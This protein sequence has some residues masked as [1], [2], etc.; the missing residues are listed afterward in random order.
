MQNLIEHDIL[1]SIATNFSLGNISINDAYKLQR[2]TKQLYDYI[3]AHYAEMK[4]L[5][6]MTDESLL[7]DID[8]LEMKYEKALAELD[9]QLAAKNS[10]LAEKDSALAEKDS[11]LAKKDSALEQALLENRQLREELEKLTHR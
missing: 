1:G 11:A 3:Y 9:E 5:N 4:E 7:L 2:L 10:E 6:D 8:I